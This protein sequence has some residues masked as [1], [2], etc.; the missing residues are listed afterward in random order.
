MA[1]EKQAVYAKLPTLTFTAEQEGTF[2]RMQINDVQ[3]SVLPSDIAS[4]QN[5]AV[6]EES[7]LRSKAVFAFRSKYSSNKV[8]ITLPISVNPTVSD[9]DADAASQK[10]GLKVL[11]QLTKYPYCFIRSARVRSY[12]SA[13]SR[14][15]STGFMIFAVDEINVVQDQRSPDVLF[16][17]F[18]LLYCDFTPLTDD[19]CFRGE[20]IDESSYQEVN[21]PANS[22]YFTEAF[23]FDFEKTYEKIFSAA[24]DICLPNGDSTYI[25]NTSTPFNMVQLLAPSV[26]SRTEIGSGD[27]DKAFVD[28]IIENYD[29]KE[30][31]ITAKNGNN[32][33]TPEMMD[34]TNNQKPVDELTT[35]ADI[36]DSTTNVL[37]YWTSFHDLSFGGVSAVQSLKF[38][39]KNKLAQQFVGSH[40]YPFIQYMGR[41]PSRFNISLKYATGEFYA[42]MEE[43][44][45]SQDQAS[46]VSTLGQLNNVLDYN[47][48]M[49]PEASAYNV[50]KINSIVAKLVGLES[51]VPNQTFISASSNP[52]S[53]GT[54]DVQIS[55]V[56]ADVDDFMQMSKPFPGRPSWYESGNSV[57]AK[58]LIALFKAYRDPAVREKVL[59]GDYVDTYAEIG[60]AMSEALK[61]GAGEFYGNVDADKIFE[62]VKQLD[63]MKQE[64]AKIEDKEK[65]T[66]ADKE[67]NSFVRDAELSA[68]KNYATGRSSY[69]W[70]DPW[71][72]G[73]GTF[74]S[75]NNELFISFLE[76][77]AKIMGA[78]EDSVKNGTNLGLQESMYRSNQAS[79]QAITT[80][81][82]ALRLAASK[83]DEVASTIVKN[84]ADGGK[85]SEAALIDYAN[86][87]VGT[88]LE[89]LGLPALAD[90]TVSPF[91]F[92]LFKPYFSS[93][94]LR[95]LNNSV[96]GE[97]MKGLE[98]II[99]KKLPDVEYDQSSH[100]GI[101]NNES[102]VTV[103]EM[104]VAEAENPV[105]DYWS[106]SS[107]GY[108]GASYGTGTD[109]GGSWEGVPG[110]NANHKAYDSLIL[111]A[112]NKHGISPGLVKS[113]IHQESH[114]NPNAY[115]KKSGATGLMQV[116]PSTATWIG[117]NG[118]LRNPSIAIE[119]GTK[120]LAYL[121]KYFKGDMTK[122]VAGYN[123]GPGNVNKYG[124]TPPFR[125]TQDYV[126]KVLGR[127]KS[128]Y[129]DDSLKAVNAG[130]GD[131][132]LAAANNTNTT[133]NARAIQQAKLEQ[134]YN[135]GTLKTD[136]L[137]QAK[138][139]SVIDGDTVWVQPL[140]KDG[141]P[142][143]KKVEIRIKY[144]DTPEKEGSFDG[145]DPK[146]LEGKAVTATFKGNPGGAAATDLGKKLMPA[147]SII[148][149]DPDR[150]KDQYG[151][152]LS[153]IYLNGGKEL[154]AEKI[155]A[156]GL[157]A[158]WNY[159]QGGGGPILNKLKSMSGNFDSKATTAYKSRMTQIRYKITNAKNLEEVKAILT[160]NKD[161]LSS[162][163]FTYGGKEYDLDV[164]T[165]TAQ[166]HLNPKPAKPN[167]AKPNANGNFPVTNMYIHLVGL[168]KD[169]KS[170]ESLVKD[171][172]GARSDSRIHEGLDITSHGTSPNVVAAAGGKA[173]TFY[174]KGGGK[175]VVIDHENGFVTRYMHLSRFGVKHGQTV[176]A[177]QG[178]GIVGNTNSKSGTHDTSISKILKHLHMETWVRKS[179]NPASNMYAVNPWNTTALNLLD[180]FDKNDIRKNIS[181][182]IRPQ[183]AVMGV[184]AKVRDRVYGYGGVGKAGII[185]GAAANEAPA[186]VQGSTIQAR[187]QGGD[188]D[189]STYSTFDAMPL[190]GVDITSAEIREVEGLPPTSSVYYE[191]GSMNLHFDNM[192]YHSNLSMNVAFPVIKVYVVIGNEIEDPFFYGA[193]KLNHY[194]E[195]KGVQD[196]RI[197]CNNDDTPVDTM[198]MS[199][200]N[201][202]FIRTDN[203]AVAGI[204]VTRDFTHIATEAEV[205]F[206][207]DRIKLFPG[208]R[209][210]VRMGYSNNPNKL[211]TVFNGVITELGNESS[212]TLSVLAEGYGRELLLDQLY[213]AKPEFARSIDTPQL[214]SRAL[215]EVKGV[216]SFG[217][218]VSKYK[219]Y[220]VLKDSDDLSDPETKRLTTN[221]ANVWN[222]FEPGNHRQR[223]YTNIYAAEIERLHSNYNTSL[224]NHLQLFNIFN[225]DRSYINEQLGFGY[226]FNGQTSWDVLKEMEFRHPGTKV[227]PLFYQD[228]MTMFFGLKEQMYIARDLDPSYMKTVSNSKDEEMKGDYI[229][230]RPV[231][232][233]IVT[234]FH[235]ASSE[236]N[237]LLN[238]MKINNK[239][240]TCV[241]VVYF[242]N[243]S[244]MANNEQEESA[245]F[246]MKVDDTIT[247]FDERYGTLRMRGIHGKYSA[248]MYGT[249]YLRREAE[250]M[251]GGTI[252]LMGNPCIKAGDYVYL[253]DNMRRFEGLIKVRECRH[254]MNA[255]TGFTTEIVPGL[256]VEARNFIY[257][258]LM[259]KL[260][261]IAKMA[262][263]NSTFA[264]NI[265]SNDEVDF[266]TYQDFLEKLKF[267]ARRKGDYAEG[268]GWDWAPAAV[269]N[270][271]Y[272]TAGTPILGMA[273]G[274]G[275][276]WSLSRMVLGGRTATGILAKAAAH[277]AS[278]RNELTSMASAANL[279]KGIWAKS[280]TSVDMLKYSRDTFKAAKTSASAFGMLKGGLGVAGAASWFMASRSLM[281][282]ASVAS[283]ALLTNPIGWLIRAAVSLAFAYLG[284]KMQEEELTRQPLLLLPIANNGRPFLAGMSGYRYDSFIEAKKENWRRNWDTISK[285]SYLVS[286]T[287]QDTT[288]KVLGAWLDESYVQDRVE[289][290]KKSFKNH[291]EPDTLA[292]AQSEQAKKTTN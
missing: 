30:I 194:F 196:V 106:T 242:D 228:R 35:A 264:L 233:D 135:D 122:V 72:L 215:A 110:T 34:N 284:A 291:L 175:T 77:R 127:W 117:V 156:A 227:K 147:N 188:S 53:Q 212:I 142:I 98:E 24:R 112:A 43:F 16:A 85:I 70:P 153:N 121:Q 262:L 155:V 163:K 172:F 76:R 99:T 265:A 165:D 96:E 180:G 32:S 129:N 87:Y 109:R 17:E 23:D 126:K 134:R 243:A 55:F 290:V 167:T 207:A 158:P 279:L 64:T 9:T 78:I 75:R 100:F 256:F 51:I 268:L 160:A 219:H 131:S 251:Y 61:T 144:V 137:Q 272:E 166:D 29:Y 45:F 241:N 226:A 274:L 67:I 154:Y 200:A 41:Y 183:Q 202:S 104:R 286:V 149:I 187:V 220:N 58:A 287:S 176:K 125:E 10:D 115:N 292:K 95:N 257:S 116:L 249:T 71:L 223:L 237:I 86:S 54:E 114:F 60:K 252:T 221:Y 133:F 232:F 211:R 195:I 101:F 7:Y 190:D 20:A 216:N 150:E 185:S 88:N 263:A 81:Y 19:F 120:Y 197:N 258:S 199:I 280:G 168:Q 47:N 62:A 6:F 162:S 146:T 234:G 27:Y 1:T 74:D 248:F 208:A 26:I 138:V 230:K 111:A 5:N 179:N 4:F 192:A 36:S 171:W 159:E 143:G 161:L 89:D 210:H 22:Q 282:L 283:A 157:G 240:N 209:L 189:F 253:N 12:I 31:K 255:Q 44:G 15:S 128:L 250:K 285:A 152:D 28:D 275:S 273:M 222:F 68:L 69:V 14:I 57:E 148:W 170:N 8:I 151:R 108:I 123:A 3:L 50:I 65:Q 94:T 25:D 236:T 289:S 214:I 181:K 132:R 206:M 59:K 288:A 246:E 82:N 184:N 229:L 201:P 260:A 33:F 254:Y 136:N 130:S 173:Y 177:G 239:Y 245:V 205:S 39:F 52:D 191:K 48:E 225:S 11:T 217:N 92:L 193:V 66:A 21:D 169:D 93:D 113:V 139:T 270:F 186:A 90:P 261:F 244:E 259:L 42:R 218:K 107:F 267:Y 164:K 84:A 56:E 224:K 73:T 119:A 182:F 235:I 38:S 18:H 266:R 178:I 63:D 83:D 49:F 40:K 145:D 140:D 238:N 276:A 141:K 46:V 79:N 203:A 213:P 174:T 281:T 80:A 247:S 198:V 2:E 118:D 105:G 103:Q 204:H 269:N 91:Y 277:S 37:I 13:R 102:G 97:I 271:V 231:R 124:G 278:I